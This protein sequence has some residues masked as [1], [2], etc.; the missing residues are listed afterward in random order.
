MAAAAPKPEPVI[1]TVEGLYR[2]FC[3]ELNNTTVED[4]M[5]RT[6]HFR[7]EQFPHLIKLEHED[8]NTGEWTA[9]KAGVVLRALE[10][11]RFDARGHRFDLSRAKA[12]FRIPEILRCPDAVHS[13]MHP[14]VKGDEVYL[15]RPHGRKGPIKVVL[16]VANRQGEIVPVTSFWS[17]EGW[18]RTCA[19]QP[20]LWEKK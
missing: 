3:D 18:L 4:P 12:L 16:V 9:A 2:R 14:R 20:P 6:I 7:L 13:N 15:I 5:G 1:L 8:K 11:G 19:K 17:T 10:E